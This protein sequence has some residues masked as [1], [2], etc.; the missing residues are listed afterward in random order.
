MSQS[1]QD[2][3]QI[4]S[5]SSVCQSST[6]LISAGAGYQ[7]ASSSVANYLSLRQEG[8][9]EL[10]HLQKRPN[11]IQTP[12]HRPIPLRHGISVPLQS[13]TRPTVRDIGEALASAASNQKRPTSPYPP[14]ALPTSLPVPAAAFLL[15]QQQQRQ[16]LQALVSD[17]WRHVSLFQNNHPLIQHTASLDSLPSLLPPGGGHLLGWAGLASHPS[18]QPPSALLQSVA[19]MSSGRMAPEPLHPNFGATAD[20]GT[21]GHLHS[22][23]SIVP[24]SVASGP[25]LTPL[26]L[27]LYRA[28]AALHHPQAD[29]HRSLDMSAIQHSSLVAAGSGGLTQPINNRAH[30]Y[31]GT[32][33]SAPNLAAKQIK[34]DPEHSN[35]L[36]PVEPYWSTSNSSGKRFSIC[37][38]SIKPF[39]T[40][41][42]GGYVCKQCQKPFGQLSNLKVHLR[43]HSGERPYR[44][45]KC[46][47]GMPMRSK[48]FGT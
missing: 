31:L 19:A 34:I 46:N 8:G 43:T 6:G 28:A 47:K 37:R 14:S 1:A 11:V 25:Q 40:G 32:P 30:P 5:T 36:Q 27:D 41:K 26:Q 17:Y 12:L 16:Q 39:N 4:Q 9:D 18:N 15:Q 29:N 22:L 3:A 38:L 48:K 13:G 24:P 45:A 10:T 2:G 7:H 23:T 20:A 33:I 44:C 35:R 42:S 21:R